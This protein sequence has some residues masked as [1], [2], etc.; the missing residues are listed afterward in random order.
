MKELVERI[1]L[2]NAIVGVFSALIAIL[3]IGAGFDFDANEMLEVL[4]TVGLV[5]ATL[6]IATVWPYL[7]GRVIGATEEKI[8]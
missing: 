2:A 5:L 4:I 7:V 1:G 8:G 6:G 3:I